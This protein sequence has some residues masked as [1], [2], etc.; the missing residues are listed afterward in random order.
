M[1]LNPPEF[2]VEGYPYGVWLGEFRD[3]V[4]RNKFDAEQRVFELNFMEE[5]NYWDSTEEEK[6]EILDC[7]DLVDDYSVES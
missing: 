7:L 6:R 3:S 5:C 4:Q 1:K 2:R